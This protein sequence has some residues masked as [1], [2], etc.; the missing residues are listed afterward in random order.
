MSVVTGIRRKREHDDE[1]PHAYSDNGGLA[2]RGGLFVT[3]GR[4]LAVKSKKKVA[5]PVRH[6][7]K[8]YDLT[9]RKMRKGDITNDGILKHPCVISLT[10]SVHNPMQ[11]KEREKKRHWKKPGNEGDGG[12]QDN[13]IGRE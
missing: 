2:E 1:G 7:G 12:H 6:P 5:H 8:I 4:E 3:R 9:R 11:K 13:K 10:D